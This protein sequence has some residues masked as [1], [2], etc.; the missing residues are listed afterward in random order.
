MVVGQRLILCHAVHHFF[1]HILNPCGLS[2]IIDVNIHLAL[3]VCVCV[4][5]RMRVCACVCVFKGGHSVQAT[6]AL[7]DMKFVYFHDFV[8][9]R[10]SLITSVISHQTSHR[11]VRLCVGGFRAHFQQSKDDF[12]WIGNS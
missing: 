3:C 9:A 12:Q 1:P 5:E 2:A 11:E 10:F 8:S 4:C 7:Q 6:L